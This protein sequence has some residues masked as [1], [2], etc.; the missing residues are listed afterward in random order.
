MRDNNSRRRR[1]NYGSRMSELA[2][3]MVSGDTKAV[4]RYYEE[5]VRYGGKMNRRDCEE[6]MREFRAEM[7]DRVPSKREL[8]V[9]KEKRKIKSS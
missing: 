9:R 5:L 6:F 4:A 1:R 3:A 7:E 8:A 2:Y